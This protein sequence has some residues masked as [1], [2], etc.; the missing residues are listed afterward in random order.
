MWITILVTACSLLLPGYGWED[1]DFN[2]ISHVAVVVEDLEEAT[3]F[4]KDLGGMEV[5]D[6]STG[7][8]RNG[9]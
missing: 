2:G 1:N 7:K 3:K 4:Y 8:I 5:E 9:I 6:L